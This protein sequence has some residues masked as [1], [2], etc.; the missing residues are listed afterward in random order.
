MKKKYTTIIH[1]RRGNIFIYVFSCNA[2]LAEENDK[3]HQ[4]YFL[5][6]MDSFFLLILVAVFFCHHSMNNPG[7]ITAISLIKSSIYLII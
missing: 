6:L 3:F 5:F 2:N 1:Y 7:K 4:V